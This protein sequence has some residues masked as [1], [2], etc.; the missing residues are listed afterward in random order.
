VSRR[1]R[2]AGF[3]AAAA[4]CA[5][6]AAGA[7]GGAS[8]DPA[9]QFGELREVVVAKRPLAR[10]QPL[11]ERVIARALEIR[12]VPER[13]LAP[14]ALA[15]PAQALGR[16]PATPIP[17]GGYLLGS[18]LEIPSGD[19][20]AAPRLGPGR[21]PLEVTVEGAGAL[22]SAEPGGGRGRV[23]VVVTTEPGPGGGAGRTYVAARSVA[24]LDLRPAG[25]EAGPDDVLSGSA[26]GSW[27]AT[28]AVSRGQSL[29]L[30]QAES[31]A[32]GIRLIGR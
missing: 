18:Q 13:F 1:G 16:A 12:R 24:L 29:E 25:D 21:Q 20:R 19:T 10:G 4:V 8:G 31:F 17:A 5:G 11:R 22:A 6:L 28:L 3:A 9:T 30:I 23:D 14:D 26:T 2:A 32:R 27:V 7:T 15:N